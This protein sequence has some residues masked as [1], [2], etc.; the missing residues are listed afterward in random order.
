VRPDSVSVQPR[1]PV[2]EPEY[3]KTYDISQ[4]PG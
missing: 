3:T 4:I 2:R 1:S